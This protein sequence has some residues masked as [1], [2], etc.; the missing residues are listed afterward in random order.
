MHIMEG[1]LPLEWALFWYLLS[2]PFVIWGM[3]GVK[4]L[5]GN[6]PKQKILLA[7]SGA[8]IFVLSSLKLPSVTG[9]SSHPTGTGMAAILYGPAVA[10]F[11]ATIVLLFQ[12]VLLAHGGITTLGADIF[13]MGI[14]GPLVAWAIFKATG[15][16]K[17]HWTVRVF[18]AALL[19]DWVTY[20]V[21]SLQLALAY[22][23][24]DFVASFF[25]FA[26]VFALTQIPLAI[27]EGVLF[28]VFFDFLLRSK[29]KTI[30]GL[31]GED[32]LA[33]SAPAKAHASSAPADSA[34]K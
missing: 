13:S 19:S 29:P 21:T 1:F 6:D 34:R 23:G 17:L 18:F 12:A 9:S 26:V 2:A 15:P 10:A 4:K 7:V 32:M 3:L 24:L 25:T 22:P 27:A 30:S 8:F 31:I 11:L 14:A 5:V 20:L 33:N 16:L 28:V